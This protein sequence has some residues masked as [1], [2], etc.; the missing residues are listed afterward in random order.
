MTPRRARSQIHASS[1]R[2][3][4]ACR[5]GPRIDGE[6]CLWNALFGGGRLLR[7]DP[8]GKIGR[9]LQVPATNPTACTFGG[10][11]LATLFITSARFGLTEAQCAADRSEGAL[12]AVET[13][14]AGA[15]DHFAGF[16][17]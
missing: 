3:A 4:P 10:P 7:F 6:G 9:E 17:R 15:A 12:F 14:I 1:S 5:T 13:G 2:A 11:D 16:P 8:D